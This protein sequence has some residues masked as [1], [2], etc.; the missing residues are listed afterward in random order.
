MIL[1]APKTLW[2]MV[3][4]RGSVGGKYGAK[5]HLSTHRLRRILQAAQGLITIA[6]GGGGGGGGWGAVSTALVLFG[7]EWWEGGGGD[8]KV[9]G[10][11]NWEELGVGEE[12]EELGEYCEADKNGVGTVSLGGVGSLALNSIFLFGE[13]SRKEKSEKENFWW[14]KKK[15]RVNLVRER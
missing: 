2:A 1:L 3:N 15:R 13:E 10:E 8:G 5:T 11:D 14:K 12:E 6:G 9:E 4:L 7:E